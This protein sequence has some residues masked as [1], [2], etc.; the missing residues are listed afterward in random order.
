MTMVEPR[1]D[2]G[3][4]S[5]DR[6][7]E[8]VSPA[9]AESETAPEHVAVAV[10]VPRSSAPPPPGSGRV[11]SG[12]STARSVALRALEAVDNGAYANL[13]LP[14]LLRNADRASSMSVR[15]KAFA[16]ELTYGTVRM[17]RAC[18]WLIDRHITRELDA[19]TRRVL[20]LGAY[21][22]V[23]LHTP[24]HA[25]VSATVD[26][27][28]RRSRGFV[29]AVL[30][31]I[32]ADLDPEWPDFA[33]SLSY[34]DWIYNRLSRELGEILAMQVMSRMNEPAM[35][36]RR[37]DGYVQDP[38]SQMVGEFLGARAGERVLDLC[39]APGGKATAVAQTGAEV[40]ALDVHAHRVRLIAENVR[41]LGL[42][43]RVFPIVADATAPPFVGGG[44][45]RVLVD[46]PCSGLGSLRR[47]ADARWRITE[48]DIAGLVVLQRA[49]LRAAADQVCIGGWIVYSACT[50]T[51]EESTG[52]DN[53]VASSLPQ[54][55]IGPRPVGDGWEPLG[56]GSR[57]L[58]GDTDGMVAFTYRRFE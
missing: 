20:Q 58:P 8:P 35:V 38:A 50:L 23:F 1:P 52:I 30:R 17:R 41:T 39:A 32:S 40:F 49:L 2:A 55:E 7:S 46:A 27:A 21:Q 18:D 16:T 56:R 14:E 36:T 10:P 44:F 43:D 19:G 42:R 57:L 34:P 47:R 6:V 28:P 5:G 24:P 31:K 37:L 51:A 9:H 26:L 25:G 12:S 3:D 45:E 53:W 48:A 22:L 4:P 15:D 13:A 33:T 54:L 29:N 11:V